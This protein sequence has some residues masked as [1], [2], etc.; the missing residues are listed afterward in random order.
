VDSQAIIFGYPESAGSRLVANHN[1]TGCISVAT[2][3][4][5]VFGGAFAGTGDLATIIASHNG[6]SG[7]TIFLD[8][9]MV[10]PFAAARIISK[11]NDTGLF[12]GEG[13]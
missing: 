9:T 12:L 1:Q 4:L 8:G 11:H 2:G 6:G 5:S 13:G 10:S 3:S 7:I